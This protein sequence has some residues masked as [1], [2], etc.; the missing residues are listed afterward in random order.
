MPIPI[1]IPPPQIKCRTQ[2]CPFWAFSFY[3]L[4]IAACICRPIKRR[5]LLENTFLLATFRKIE[6]SPAVWLLAAGAPLSAFCL[7]YKSQTL[8]VGETQLG[9]QAQK[10]LNK[11]A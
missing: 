1:R 8:G 11:F 9:S 6:N 3:Y 2:A 7:S 4:F 5:P 10:V